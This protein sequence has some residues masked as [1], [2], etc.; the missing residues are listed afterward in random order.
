MDEVCIRSALGISL[1]MVPR[2]MIVTVVGVFAR[3]LLR[4]IRKASS[5]LLLRSLR[6]HLTFLLGVLPFQLGQPAAP[7]VDQ[8]VSYLCQSQWLRRTSRRISRT[9]LVRGQLRPVGELRLLLLRRVRVP[10]VGLEPLSEVRGSIFWQ[11]T[12]PF[13]SAS[14]LVRHPSYFECPSCRSCIEELRRG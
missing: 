1:V 10:P 2:K 8:P 4:S 9:R 14:Y 7:G 6:L 11:V 5:V 13:P 12:P 3:G